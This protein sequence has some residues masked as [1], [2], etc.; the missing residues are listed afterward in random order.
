[1]NA[2]IDKAIIFL[3]CCILYIQSG[4][5]PYIIIPVLL[6][7]IFSS[8]FTIT[9]NKAVQ[10]ITFITYVVLCIFTKDFIY[11]MPL[12]CYDIFSTKNYYLVLIAILPYG[13]NFNSLNLNFQMYIPI[14]TV[15]ACLM[16]YRDTFEEKSR[17]EY[18]NFRDSSKE[19]SLKLEQK[20]KD[21]MEKQDYEIN[22]ATLNERNR[23][24][25]EIHD[26]VGH[27]LS[28]SILQLGALMSTCNDTTLVNNLKTLK[29]TLSE[30]MD[31]IRNS[32]H[33]I[34][35]EYIDLN[36]DINTIISKFTF[37]DI[38]LNYNI[39]INPSKKYKIC[40][41]SIIKE[42]LSNVIKHSNATKVEITLR[43]HPALYQLIIKDN[44]NKI[45]EET[46]DGIGVKNMIHRINSL[47]GVININTDNGYSIFISLPK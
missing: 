6:S 15:I 44:G 25:R 13:A 22:I 23:I 4:F 17:K 16:K 40:F 19:L 14:L 21:L 43:E 41:I 42:A 11:F 9:N 31:S 26:N 30:G 32:I 36:N 29:Q 45:N 39:K 28:S 7:I 1:M 38:S 18:I 24:A 27:L 37:C 2:I 46:S 47:N 5:N 12:L 3:F 10:I 34:H 8:I 20:N 35:D 33:N